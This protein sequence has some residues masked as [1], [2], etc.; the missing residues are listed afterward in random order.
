MKLRV[1]WF[2][3]RGADPFDRE[4]ETYRSRVDRRWAA[5]DIAHRPA[6]GGRDQ[7]PARALASEAEVARRTDY[8]LDRFSLTDAAHRRMGGY[9]KGM[10]QKLKLAQALALVD[11]VRGDRDRAQERDRLRLDAVARSGEL[12][13]LGTTRETGSP[14]PVLGLDAVFGGHTHDGMPVPSV[15]RNAAGGR[16]VVTNAGSNGKFLA[17]LDLDLG[18]G[19]VRDFRY[20][21][22]PVFSNLLPA[23]P[24]MQAYIEGVRAPYQERLDET[25]AVAE[26]VLYR[27]G[28]FSGTFDQLICDGLRAVGDA[29]IAL[30]P[31]FRW[32]TSILPGQPITMERLLD[33][34]CITYPETY[35][36]DMSGEEIKLILEDVADNLFNPDPFYQQGGDMVRLGGMNYVCDPLADIGNRISDMTLDSGERIEAG[37]TYKVTGWATVGS[38]APGA[39]VWDVV[40][41]YLRA[42]KTIRI[43]RLNTP[44][45][46]NV[47]GN[48]GIADYPS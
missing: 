23:D 33:Q 30:S 43:D 10:R 48:P 45:L 32:G 47:A 28:N 9:S 29:Q 37:K 41:E 38:Q 3:R 7:D 35:V 8:W 1:V 19:R 11:V 4:V 40:A 22:L 6:A 2:G 5:E 25:L 13:E 17:V 12:T 44:V 24:E 34:T 36:R 21:L 26:T 27:R 16:T 14:G 31:G 18:L 20:R 42:E 39:P 15:V 46:K